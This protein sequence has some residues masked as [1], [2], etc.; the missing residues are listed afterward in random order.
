MKIRHKKRRKGVI[1]LEDG[2]ILMYVKDEVVYPVA[3]TREQFEMLQL[4]GKT[5]EPI[6]VVIDKP[7][8][9]AINLL[10]S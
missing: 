3:M 1:I 7:Q 5:F 2:L 6:R 8:G 10:N 4:I 9:K